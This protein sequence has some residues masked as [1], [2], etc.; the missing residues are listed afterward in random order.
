[1]KRSTIHTNSIKIDDFCLDWRLSAWK[2]AARN[3]ILRIERME[4][5]RLR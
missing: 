5:Q 3:A 4:K 1:M 2:N